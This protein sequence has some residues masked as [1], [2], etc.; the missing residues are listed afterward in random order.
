MGEGAINKYAD[1]VEEVAIEGARMDK[2][3]RANRLAIQQVLINQEA[4]TS[5]LSDKVLSIASDLTSLR[6]RVESKLIFDSK[7]P[8][9]LDLLKEQLNSEVTSAVNKNVH[10]SRLLIVRSLLIKKKS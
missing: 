9:H 8:K 4:N 5:S 2:M 6:F 7:R 10:H 1:R 3:L